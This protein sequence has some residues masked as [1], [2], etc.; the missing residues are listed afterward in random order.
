[1]VLALTGAFSLPSLM[2]SS[3]PTLSIAVIIIAAVLVLRLAM[4]RGRSRVRFNGQTV[5]RCSKGHVFTEEWSA[6]GAL[7]SIHVFGAR[8]QRCPVGDH[9]SMVKPV[10]EGSLT[11]EERRTI[12]S[13][14]GTFSS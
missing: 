9:W 14:G 7:S 8:L 6:M 13:G 1:M 11:D 2:A 3:H 12:E 10:S 5:V 4:W